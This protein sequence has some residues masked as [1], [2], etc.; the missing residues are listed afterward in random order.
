[1]GGVQGQVQLLFD[2]LMANLN[3]G[4]DD[5]KIAYHTIYSPSYGWGL[6]SPLATA[7]TS[8]DFITSAP[9]GSSS[10]YLYFDA[11]LFDTVY[12]NYIQPGD[13]ADSPNIVFVIWDG[14]NHYSTPPLAQ[15]AR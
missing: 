8:A 3:I 14:D 5:T 9:V 12:T 10:T 13:R 2:E 6:N 4:E 11:V 7:Y 1:M 15:Q